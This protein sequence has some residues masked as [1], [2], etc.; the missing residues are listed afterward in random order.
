ME[1]TFCGSCGT[2]R[3]VS[4][5]SSGNGEVLF[6]ETKPKSNKTLF[7]I[8]LVASILAMVGSVAT[9]VV[10]NEQA[11]THKRLH[12]VNVTKANEASI[13]ADSWNSLL[14][15]SRVSKTQC[16]Y[17]WYCSAATYRVWVNLVDTQEGYAADASANAATY[18]ATANAELKKQKSAESGRMT[19]VVFIVV[20]AVGLVAALI[21]RARNRKARTL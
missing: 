6:A 11:M 16:Y 5:D 9:T 2:A 18:Q 14:A 20:S 12:D 21:V 10:Q 1:G 15:S 4:L 7:L 17:N 8:L 3:D 13:E 19:G